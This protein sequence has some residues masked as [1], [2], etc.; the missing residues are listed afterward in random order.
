MTLT[1]RIKWWINGI[2]A[3]IFIMLCIIYLLIRPIITQNLEP[4]IKNAAGAR[5]NGTLT[6][7]MM[8]L[9]PNYDLSFADLELKDEKGEVVFKSP[10]LEIGWSASALYKYVAS[11]GGL[12]DV[13]KTVTIES[14]EVHL[15]K[16]KDGLWNVENIL[17]PSDTP[18]NGTFTG[19]VIIKDGTA[20]V[21]A[22]D[23]GSYDFTSLGA[24][25]G[26]DSAGTITGSFAGGAFDSHFTG[27]LKYTNTSNMEINLKTDPVSLP[28]LKP[29]LEQFPQISSKLDIDKGTG[30]V[31][32]AKIWKSDGAV[33]YHVQG[34]IN[35]AALRYENY[36]LADGAAFFDIENDEAVI[37]EA[38]IKVNGQTFTGNAKVLFGVDDP[39][40]MGHVNLM[41]VKTEELLAEEGITAVVAG[42]V[43]I[44]GTMGNPFVSGEITVKDGQYEN[45]SVKEA[46][47]RF[48]YGE[49]RI[50]LPY[51]KAQMAGG[52]LIGE[53]SYDMMSG[54]FEGEAAAERV[55]LSE[56]PAGI[57]AS[58]IVSGSVK[59]RG[60]YKDGVLSLEKASG[61]ADG[62]NLSYD[63]MTAGKV[64]GFGSYDH[65]N[66][67]GVFY[68]MD[69]SYDGISMDTL[70]GDM[71]S[72]GGVVDIS[73]LTGTSGEGAFTVK[74]K[75]GPSLSLSGEASSI[76]LSQFSGLSGL[77]MAGR[78]S[79]K[80][81]VSGSREDPSGAADFTARDG[82][83][84]G[85][86]FD[87]VAG[88]VSLD[89]Q[90][91]TITALHF[92]G[93]DGRHTVKGT[94]GL[95]APHF[96]ALTIDTDKTR[97]EK[98]LALA[99]E[100]YPVT[101]WIGNTMTV[102]GTMEAPQVTGD[103]QAFDGSVMGELF[104]SVSGEYTY[105]GNDITL[106]NGL[107][108]I[109][110][111]TAIVSGTVKPDMI[112]MDVSLND[113]SL[114]RMLPGR[115]ADGKV[116]MR[117]HVSGTMEDP[118]FEGTIS[119]RQISVGGTA[120]YMA[121]AGI[122][123]QNHVVRLDDGIFNQKNGHFEW[124]GS[125]HMDSHALQG[126]LRFH[127]WNIK[128]VMRLFKLPESAVDGA[129]NG[130]MRIGGTLENPSI[131][132]K[133]DFLG[134]H[135][136]DTP[137]GQ[138][139]IDFS[140]MNGA[141]SIR[142]FHLPVG[143]GLLAAEGSMNS[144]GDLAIQ[145]AAKD[146]EVSWLPQVLGRSDI[147][148]GGRLTAGVVLSGNK[149][150]PEA[151][152]SIGVDHPSY[153]DISF[154][155][156]SLMANASHNIVTLQQALISKGN[157]RASAKGTLPGNLFT[158]STTD[159]AVPLSVDFNLDQADMNILALFGKAVTS[160][161]GP[162]K[163]HVQLRGDYRDPELT[164]SITAKDGALGIMTMNEIIRPMDLSLVFD[165]HRVTFDGS[166]AFGG[167]GVT[168]KG[169][170]D[171]KEKAITHYDGEVHMH[172]PSIDSS[173]YKGAVDADFSLGEFMD[174]LGV[175]GK[176]SIHDA[177][178]EVPLALLSESGESS[179]NFLTKIDISIGDNVRLHS[180]SLYDLIVKGNISMMG[181]FQD[182]IMTGRVNVEKG[183]VKINT[184]EFKIDQANAIWGGI[185]GSFLPVVHV[186]ADT[187]VGHY[188]IK[189]ELEG[190]PGDMK[191]TFHS[192]PA[193]NDSQIIMLLTLH[194]DPTKDK[195]GS[196]Q[197][198]LFNAG[199]TM[200]FG[201]TMQDFLQD[202]IGLDLIS[203]T[204]NLTDYYDNIDDNN[205]SYYYIK[206][207]KYL[208]NDFMLTATMGV[209]NDEK[210]MGF[211]YDLNSRIG[212][213]S[214]YNSNHDSYIGSDWSF[215]F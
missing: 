75:Y 148:L 2:A 37:T 159:E 182:P 155:N 136:G 36:I 95:S 70:S 19:Q 212:L 128:E 65:G 173:Y 181:H 116:N 71:A 57:S 178:C 64:S 207:G 134:G 167:G 23:I 144:H 115:G 142:Q 44:S 152:I 121:S 210:S 79:G 195:D 29:L 166:A 174:Q 109:Y 5:I 204:S 101:G 186:R 147:R 209:N 117:G 30:Q 25:L 49:N 189:A 183:T 87:R 208:F 112:D 190:P 201:N 52:L 202:K 108:Y 58:G 88:H 107:A 102:T 73:Y 160:A 6:W 16:T 124:R 139:A 114:S 184:T 78:L 43:D 14:P 63:N 10:S 34:S 185:P 146:M 94:I 9:D 56:I 13:V 20:S 194:Q 90:M 26:W 62:L 106:K 11:N 125:Y 55:D 119:S 100:D 168:A 200:L 151:D 154:D 140:Y 48:V 162:I 91:A 129:V 98:L 199:L 179:A 99:G 215:K 72:R 47:V 104:Q 7:R 118:V 205:D 33:A 206:I 12:A 93:P 177:T 24:T 132:F 213:S 51:L 17:K 81:V 68:G 145:L 163:G 161:S 187:K 143:D 45:L 96:L 76:D 138:G 1:S 80:F 170:I 133:A 171:W 176:I 193:L 41:D 60:V 21:S 111:G 113:I 4:V 105:D 211:H 92:E 127:A 192:D 53:G 35:D 54:A 137:V 120:I 157:Y 131:D 196:M 77:D 27:D 150:S 169:S 86:S 123:Y 188:N 103:F 83:I 15:A 191:T 42:G 61:E 85:I 31:T 156:F 203:I 135:L 67:H 39:I 84:R 214:W 126:F 175:T 153:G 158:G 141:L 165:G 164:G 59:A 110:D 69:L 74:G 66:W 40:L 198:A 46:N 22:P 172:T 50:S 197:G 18:D 130:G 3:F 97:I 122:Y 82:E 38:A 28:S 32:S 8:D 149:A 89:E 180:S